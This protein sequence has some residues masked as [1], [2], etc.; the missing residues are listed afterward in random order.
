[1]SGSIAT[2]FNQQ[3]PQRSWR[4]TAHIIRELQPTEPVYLFCAN[5]LGARAKQ[6]YDGFSG[7]VSYAVKANPEPRILKT[8]AAAGI[9]HFDVASIAEIQVVLAHCPRRFCTTTI[10]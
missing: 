5:T 4:G 9:R 7:S 2:A 1:M 6:F 10:L 8:L 3:P